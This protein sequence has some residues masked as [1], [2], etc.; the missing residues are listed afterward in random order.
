MSDI[1]ENAAEV[2]RSRGAT[3]VD[4]AFVLGT[5]LGNMAEAV[6]NPIA[7]P[8]ADLPG[9]PT[10]TVSGHDGHL[11][12]GA[13]EGVGVAY[14]QGRAH[15]YEKG[16]PRCME[17][18]LETLALLG[19]QIVVFTAAVGSVNADLYP[20]NLVMITD[21]INFSGLNPLI[22]AGGDG[23][24]V[25]M[26][27]AYDPRLARRFK[28]ATLSSGVTL[29]EGVY[30]WFSGPSFETPAEIKMA[31]ALGADVVGMSV[32]PEVILA[33]RLGLRVAAVVIVSNFGANFMGGNPSHLET[34]KTAAQGAIMLRRL[35]K[36][37]L[38]IREIEQ[39]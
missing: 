33:R 4:I 20:G 25:A 8:Y 11:V 34:R 10:L 39:Q 22:G 26:A 7:I 12:L 19:A 35:I 28:R 16:D 6:E 13:Q 1:A 30:M 5:G 36:S 14:M 23:G 31:K 21:H 37:F 9:F 17:T 32:A 18:P 3:G 15:Y 27:E 29:R 24:F 38:K 2:A